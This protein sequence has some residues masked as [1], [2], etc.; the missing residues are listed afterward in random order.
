[1]AQVIEHP[2]RQTM[3]TQPERDD[4]Q[5]L[6]QRLRTG[7]EAAFAAIVD[8]WSPMMLHMARRYVADQAAAEDVVQ[9][10]WLGVIKGLGRFEGRSTLRSWTFSIMLNQA[11]S[12]GFRDRRV[13]ASSVLSGDEADKPTVDPARFQPADGGYPGNWTSAGAPRPWE[14]P[15]HRALGREATQLLL[16]GLEQLPER[17]RLVIS[18]RDMVG[19]S[20]KE[21][22]VALSVS[23]ENQRVL[24]HRARAALRTMLEDYHRA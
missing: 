3:S 19:M 11:R 23:P 15:E 16:A 18:M 4:E 17:Q 5:E 7:D 21:T 20:S 22:C 1:M 13:I 14:Q 24:L 9:E 2:D 8:A 10:T 12:R 6:L